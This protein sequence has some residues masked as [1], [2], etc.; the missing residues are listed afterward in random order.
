[1]QVIASGTIHCNSC[2][3]NGVDAKGER[4]MSYQTI[5]VQL[6]GT[7]RDAA[8]IAA[9]ARIGAADGAHIVGLFVVHPFYPSLGNFGDP[10]VGVM[11][12]L[13]CQ[14]QDEAKRGADAIH[15]EVE[16]VCKA[17]GLPFEWRCEE[18]FAEDIVPVHARYADLCIM[19]QPDPDKMEPSA[20]QALPI[21][22]VMN[23]GRPVLVIPYAGDHEALG[24]NVL[25]GWNGS[26]EATR[27]AHDA[28]PLLKKA[29]KVSVVSIDSGTRDHIAGFDI[30]AALARHGVN[31]EAVRT[32][33]GDVGVG[34]IILSEAADLGA[35]LIV[36]GGYGHS[37]LRELILGG[38][39]ETLMNAMTVPV[40]MSH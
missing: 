32:V 13:H 39:S 31:A 14:Y 20:N 34:E 33:A 17:A 40:L 19:G 15:T 9:A 12:D 23:A 6:D 5:L 26:R 8:R 22:T 38:V 4:T 18:G 16:G 7:G 25:I 1:M 11:A 30:S 27:A 37:R 10:A 29:A 28:L 2:V 21:V 35:N 36:V 3:Q 24:T